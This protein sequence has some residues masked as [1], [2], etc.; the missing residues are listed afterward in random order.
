MQMDILRDI[1]LRYA[2]KIDVQYE[3]EIKPQLNDNY[4]Q[5]A[6]REYFYDGGSF[7]NTSTIVNS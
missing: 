1:S 3:R 5:Q 2:K 4:R 7:A 6:S